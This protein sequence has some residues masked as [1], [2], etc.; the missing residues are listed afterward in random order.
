MGSLDRSIPLYNVAGN[1]DIGN[2][3]TPATIAAY[4]ARFGKD[5]YTFRH[6]S[7]LGIVL[8][9]T[10]IHSPQNVAAEL[11]DQDRFL[12]AELDNAASS[13]ARHVVIFQHHPWF[14]ERADEA[15]STT[16]FRGSVATP[17]RLP[18]QGRRCH[19]TLHRD[20]SDRRR[21]P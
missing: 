9:S 11:D 6:G 18:R 5:Y 4:R 7:L 17:C 21:S 12:R 1:H 8:N 2:E 15:D 19:P 3:P 13:R 16:T 14:L 20:G 10:V